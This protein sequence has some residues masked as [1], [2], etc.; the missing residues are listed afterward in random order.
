MKEL[1][2]TYLLKGNSTDEGKLK[3]TSADLKDFV[4]ASQFE[5]VKEASVAVV[6]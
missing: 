3:F 4:K 6:E 2:N 1:Q 5:N